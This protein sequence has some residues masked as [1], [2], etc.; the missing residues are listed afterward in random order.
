[1]KIISCFELKYLFCIRNR[2]VFLTPLSL[3]WLVGLTVIKDAE[4]RT[5]RGGGGNNLE[6]EG[7]MSG[8]DNSTQ[9]SG[10]RRPR[11]PGRSECHPEPPPTPPSH[12]WTSPLSVSGTWA[13]AMWAKAWKIPVPRGWLPGLL[14]SPREERAGSG[15][16][17]E[18]HGVEPRAMPG[19]DPQDC[20]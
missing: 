16:G 8:I 9:S 4:G 18:S 12:P 7:C 20:R 11:P 5:A 19:W 6:G 15:G 17:A 10:W 2:S 3:L 1:M 14:S 13:G